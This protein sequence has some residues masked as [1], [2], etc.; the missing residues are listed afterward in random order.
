MPPKRKLLSE[1]ATDKAVRRRAI[2]FTDAQERHVLEYFGRFRDGTEAE[3][4]TDL[5][6]LV[7]ELTRRVGPA[8][9]ERLRRFLIAYGVNRTF[10]G[11]AAQ[12]PS[13]L[14]PL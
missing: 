4:M 9:C 11:L 10:P 13:C 8:E 5:R 1:P 14:L 12:G 6:W 2:T 3:I 7:A